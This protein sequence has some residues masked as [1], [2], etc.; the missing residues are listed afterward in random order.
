MGK[1]SMVKSEGYE[2]KAIVCTN[3]FTTE[4]LSIL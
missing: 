2:A 4:I 3:Y 1:E